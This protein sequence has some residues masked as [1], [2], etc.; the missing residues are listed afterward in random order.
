MRLQTV[1][2][3]FY[4][5]FNFD[6]LRASNP[7][8][9]ADAWD[10]THD[11]RFRPYIAV[12]IDAEMT[13]IVGANESGK[14]QLLDA[15][16]FG[17]G[18]K[19]PDD[20]DFC[21][22]SD[23]FTVTTAPQQ[24]HFGLKFSD[25][26]PDESRKL[27]DL[28]KVPEI[29]STTAFHAFRTGPGEV[30]V[31]VG[32]EDKETSDLTVL[33]EMFPRVVRIDPD[34]ALPNSVPLEY[35][36]NGNPE[37]G[38]A[39]GTARHLWRENISPVFD[40]ATSLEALLDDPKALAAT[41]TDL[42]GRSSTSTTMSDAEQQRL[43]AEM[44]LAYDLLI[45]VGG[46][47]PGAFG[48]LQQALARE[49]EGL[50][51]GI[52][53]EMN[54]QL[55]E[56]LNLAKWWTQD[57]D[58]R[59]SMDVREFHLVFTVRDKTGSNYSF[60]ERSGGLK[61]FLSYLV[62]VLAH[63]RRRQG[64]EILL[65]DEPDAYLSNQGQQDLLRVL[66]EFTVKTPQGPGGQVI[67][68]THSPFLI[69]KNR[70]DRIRV[71]D[72]GSG[73]E[74]ARVVHDV[75]HNRF[76]PLRTAM[77]S[78]IGETIFM[79]NCNVIVEGV[80][81]QVYLAGMSTLLGA[82][83]FSY[84]ERL[85]LNQVTLVP[86]G[87][88]S[89]NVSYMTYLARGRGVDKP[90]VVVLLDGDS[91]GDDAVKELTR[92]GRGRKRVLKSDYILQIKQE[93][94]PELRSDRSS[95]PLTVEDLIPLDVALK[96]L[97]NYA[98]EIAVDIADDEDTIRQSVQELLASTKSLGVFESIHQSLQDVGSELR[99]E[100]FPF[101]RHVV[102]VIKNDGRDWQPGEEMRN[103]FAA[104]FR[105]LTSMQRKADRERGTKTIIGRV[106]RE[107]SRFLRDHPAPTKADLKVLLERIEAVVDEAEE[108]DQ[109]LTSIRRMRDDYQLSRDLSHPIQD[110]EELKSGLHTLQYD[111][112]RATQ[113]PRD[114]PDGG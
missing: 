38:I 8:S 40:Y 49:N 98:D 92:T 45:T 64:P 55:E 22:Y 28:L 1:Y 76:E 89:G 95:G 41:M 6:Y 85:N 69:D 44:R 60:G 12:N 32:N 112:L 52:I 33:R 46:I 42:L 68:V 26:T 74:G 70:A 73:E 36:A 47:D 91:G 14:S 2:T 56:S 34:T 13:C 114:E 101:A 86:A 62:Q 111:E 77:G 106:E 15:I 107:R 5:A 94:F 24:P 51:N 71:L 19:E 39:A 87:G 75:G 9:S 21:R 31:Y 109:L 3:R 72:K 104:L 30:H 18:A 7:D 84:E 100:K 63:M 93:N 66:Q 54:N 10:A 88:A 37:A 80:S 35:L 43:N 25:L 48:S 102:D 16:E 105:Y 108:G 99:V 61:F 81:D 83:G 97:R 57:P 58:L 23:Y 17:A 27:S 78:F 53:G 20:A 67:F 113:E 96:A 50:A 79:G 65:M 103:R 90:A 82:E 11:E 59:L 4:R 110:L 29:S